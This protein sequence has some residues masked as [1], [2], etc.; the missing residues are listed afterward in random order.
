[1]DDD[2]KA[3]WRNTTN[4]ILTFLMEMHQIFV[5]EVYYARFFDRL[6]DFDLLLHYQIPEKMEVRL[7]PS[8]LDT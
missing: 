5:I 4:E 7:F 8:K 2:R 3:L 1:M 6:K